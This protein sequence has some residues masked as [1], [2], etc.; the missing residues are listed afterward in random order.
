MNKKLL[1]ICPYPVGCAPSQ[2]LKYEQYLSYIEQKGGYQI[3]ISPFISPAF[4]QIIYRPGNLVK[5]IYYTL[6]GYARRLKN[7]FTLYQ[8]DV[9]YIHLW[10]T[11][12][13]PPVFEWLFRKLSKKIVFDIDD[14]VYTKP[15]HSISHRLIPF[16]KGY[17]KPIYLMKHANHIITC[18]PYLDR[19]VRQ[20]NP[21]TTDISSTINTQTYLPV[22]TYTNQKPLIIG[23]SGS[24]STSPYLHLLYGVFKRL[25]Q[26]HQFTLLVM[27]DENFV[28]EGVP[29]QAV[30]WTADTEIA[31][32]QQIDIGVYPLPNE[33]WVLGK[34]GLKALQYMAL[35]IP[36]VATAIGANYR[37][38]ENG[39]SGFLV[40]TEDEWVERLSSLLSDEKLRQNIGINARK[41]VE[42]LFSVQANAGT[43]LSILNNLV[44][45]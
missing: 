4:W 37:V 36:A 21:H 20:Y 28:M 13:G 29:V 15:L 9:V 8:Y 27:G 44:Q 3:H 18:T 39:V 12:F 31:T 43:Y 38:I 32:L 45:G 22:N 25:L 1:I 16:I 40:Q 34:S 6:S 2:R 41:R 10:V 30:K 35:G 19:F 11:P 23:W 26:Q 7:L 5:K 17:G 14:L 24:K 33:E 42:Q